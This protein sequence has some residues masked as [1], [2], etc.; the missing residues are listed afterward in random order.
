MNNRRTLALACSLTPCLLLLALFLLLAGVPTYAQASLRYVAPGGDCGG[1]TPCY[2]TIQY[3]VDAANDGDVIKVATGTYI[4]M[5]TRPSPPGYVGP[6]SVDQMVYISKTV[7]IKGGYTLAFTDPPDPETNPTTLDAQ[8]QGRVLFIT[9]NIS[10][11][12]EGLHMTNGDAAGLG[13]RGQAWDAGGG[14][15]AITATI[16]FSNNWVIDNIA[17][18]GGGGGGLWLRHSSGV[19]ANNTISANTA[20][21]SCGGL[22][23]EYGVVTL[24]G[25]TITGNNGVEFGGGGLCIGYG[26]A[27]LSENTISGNSG[28]GG[29]GVSLAYSDV[30]FD[31]NII[32]DNTTGDGG[33]GVTV[34]YSSATFDGDIITGNTAGGAWAGGG[35]GVY[36]FRAMLR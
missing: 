32:S 20:G 34:G 1:F 26:S 22:G 24:R 14:V 21:W 35:G 17:W 28:L 5:H 36:L 10:P 7:T 6:A 31:R 13:G 3:A 30:T 25:N 15:Y 9:G 2:V 29:G 12:V 27:R 8:A 23:A 18:S 16:A 33:G 19:L 4:D 11:T